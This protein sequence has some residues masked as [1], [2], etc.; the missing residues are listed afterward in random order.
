MFLHQ[1]AGRNHKVKIGN[2]YFENVG[3]LKYLGKTVT[4]Q[5]LIHER[6]KSRLNSIMLVVIGF[7]I[8]V[9]SFAVKNVNIKIHRTIILPINFV[10]V[11]LDLSH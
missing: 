2:R 3:K 7:P 10:D 9:F 1:N 4:H 8:F 6:I 5:N 11:K